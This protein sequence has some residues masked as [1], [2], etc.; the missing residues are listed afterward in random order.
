MVLVVPM[1]LMVPYR[2][3]CSSFAFNGSGGLNGSIGGSSS[4]NVSNGSSA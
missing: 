2:V 3:C 4:S 1:V